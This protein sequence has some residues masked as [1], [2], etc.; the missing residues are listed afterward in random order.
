MKP[1]ARRLPAPASGQDGA[2][3]RQK[4]AVFF[5]GVVP[6]SPDEERLAEEVGMA[7]AAAGFT[8]LHGGYNGLMEA[9]ARGAAAKGGTVTAVTLAD[10]HAEWGGFNE[11]VTAEVHL[12]DLGARLNHYL[13]AADLVVA[14]G[15]GVGTLHELTAALYYAGN[16]R[17]VPVWITG[18]TALGLLSFLRR[19]RWLFETP[20]RPLGFLTSIASAAM[21]ATQLHRLTN[22]TDGTE[23]DA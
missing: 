22:G 2:Q 6:A 17:P 5:G 15:G 8:L 13:D 10:K 3:G 18:P 19:E 11:Y 4:T 16:I 9:A 1:P 21:F 14:M 20:T 12:P 7:L 23:A